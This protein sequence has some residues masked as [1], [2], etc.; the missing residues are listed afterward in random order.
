LIWMCFGRPL[1]LLFPRRPGRR[2]EPQRLGP[3][4][5]TL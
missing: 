5:Q 3:L 2:G 1:V 4:I